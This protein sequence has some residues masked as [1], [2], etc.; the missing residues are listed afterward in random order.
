MDKFYGNE[1]KNNQKGIPEEMP[2]T[3]ER[4]EIVEIPTTPEETPIPEEVPEEV[5]EEKWN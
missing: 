4:P 3:E 2:E 5:P 1:I